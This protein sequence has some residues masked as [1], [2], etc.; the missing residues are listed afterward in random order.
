MLFLHARDVVEQLALFVVN[1]T[2]ILFPYSVVI[3]VPPLLFFQI[4]G[5][6][7]LLAPSPT[8]EYYLYMYDSM[9]E[10]HII[11]DNCTVSTRKLC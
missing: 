2:I 7:S 8:R 4:N 9:Y 6:G 11:V 1:L 5:G 10:V 3:E